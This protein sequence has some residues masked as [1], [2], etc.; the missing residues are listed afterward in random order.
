MT[1]YQLLTDDIAAAIVYDTETAWSGATI[2][3]LSDVL[4][5]VA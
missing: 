3:A 1:A 5:L 4:T 2:H